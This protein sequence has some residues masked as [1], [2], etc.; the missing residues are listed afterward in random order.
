MGKGKCKGCKSCGCRDTKAQ[1]D[2]LNLLDLKDYSIENL[3]NKILLMM[4]NSGA[5]SAQFVEASSEVFF[6]FPDGDSMPIK[7]VYCDIKER[8]PKIV[9]RLKFL[10]GLRLGIN[11]VVQRGFL[12]IKRLDKFHYFIITT[13]PSFVLGESVIIDTIHPLKEKKCKRC[14]ADPCHC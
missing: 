8:F 6:I 13:L 11:N 1:K 10:A 3:V 5:K 7:T 12:K 2:H 4:I 14:K 9:S